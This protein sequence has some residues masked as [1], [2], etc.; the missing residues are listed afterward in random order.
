M[1]LNYRAN[2]VVKIEKNAS[3]CIKVAKLFTHIL[4]LN[5]HCNLIVNWSL[6]LTKLILDS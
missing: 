4:Y 3:I 6:E 1:T 2:I 5:L